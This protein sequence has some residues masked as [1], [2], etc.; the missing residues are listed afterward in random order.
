MT[1]AVLRDHL[2]TLG[3]SQAR[4]AKLL[5]VSV[6]AVE[7]WLAGKRAMPPTAVRLVRLMD[8]RSVMRALERM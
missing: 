5:G 7:L 4:A 2:A 3:L 8:R 1:P 6:D